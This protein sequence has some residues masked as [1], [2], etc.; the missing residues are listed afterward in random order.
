VRFISRETRIVTVRMAQFVNASTPMV[1][2]FR[3]VMGRGRKPMKSAERRDFVLNRLRERGEVSYAALAGE[4]M[5]SEMTIRRDLEQLVLAGHARRVRSGAISTVSSANEPAF[6]DRSSLASGAKQ[7]IGRAAAQLVSD[8][9]TII[10]DIGTTALEVARALVDTRNRL[11]IVTPSL[12]AAVLLN[13]NATNTVILTGG[14]L[15]QDEL[16]VSGPLASSTFA[17]VNCDV[18]FIGVA[19]IGA[20]PGITDF[21]LPDAQVKVTA[22]RAARRVIVLADQSK[23]GHVA[24]A[25]IS[26]LDSVDM[27]VTDAPADLPALAPIRATGL[28]IIT[29]DS[30]K[31]SEEDAPSSP[32]DIAKLFSGDA[33]DVKPESTET[34]ASG[35]A[36]SE[37]EPAQV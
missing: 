26:S 4:L 20:D 6:V 27:L 11:T 32:P 15:R 10:I 31:P 9:D 28:E 23:I 35:P 24:F 5:V 25:T 13:S 33:Q 1:G 30:G 17:S 3:L 36:V 37:S 2:G 34:L 22:M 29:A 19:G 8:G 7:A 12:P 18:A 21:N 14:Q 16:G